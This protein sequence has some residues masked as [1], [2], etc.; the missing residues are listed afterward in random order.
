MSYPDGAAYGALAFII[1]GTIF[2]IYDELRMWYC[3]R[4]VITEEEEQPMRD[5]YNS[6]KDIDDAKLGDR[7]KMD[8]GETTHYGWSDMGFSRKGMKEIH[9]FLEGLTAE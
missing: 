8:L 9:A 7:L 2:L 3:R 6:W 4:L 1:C 5:L